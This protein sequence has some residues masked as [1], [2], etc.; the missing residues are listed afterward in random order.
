MQVIDGRTRVTLDFNNAVNMSVDELEK[1]LKGS[2]SKTAGWSKDDGSGEAIGHESY[3]LFEV[4]D[5]RG[6]KIVE[7]LKKNPEKDP[8]KYDEKDIAHMRR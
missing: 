2:K 3:V 6:R 4:S 1:W 8:S 5:C 7:I